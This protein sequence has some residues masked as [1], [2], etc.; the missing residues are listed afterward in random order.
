MNKSLLYGIIG[1]VLF[2]A[3]FNLVVNLQGDNNVIKFF[4][5]GLGSLLAFIGLLKSIKEIK[6]KQN[7]F[8]AIVGLLLGI[9]I[10]VLPILVLIFVFTMF[11]VRSF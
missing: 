9:G 10:G 8:Q 6:L 7:R 1:F 2:G 4:G 5:Y 3:T 11:A